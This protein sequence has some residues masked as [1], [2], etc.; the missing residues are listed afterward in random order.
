MVDIDTGVGAKRGAGHAARW[1][2]RQGGPGPG[3]APTLDRVL[4]PTLEPGPDLEP[5]L[6]RL[7][8][9]RPVP[10]DPP[11]LPDLPMLPDLAAA[12]F[13]PSREDINPLA[14]KHVVVVG[15]HYAPE[16]TGVAPYTTAM[17]EHLA[18][19]ARLVTVLTGLPH[20]PTWRVPA[21]YRG[22]GRNP[23]LHTPTLHLVRHTHSVPRRMTPWS[24]LRYQAGF[25]LR[26]SRTQLTEKPDLV[27]AVT[28]SPSSAIAGARLAE[29]YGCPLV[30]VVHDLT[31]S[32]GRLA[33]DLGTGAI[34][35]ARP[36]GTIAKLE[37]AA[38]CR[39]DRVVVRSEAM[40]GA[41]TAC[42]VAENRVDAVPIWPALHPSSLSRND[43][44][45]R[46]GWARD[47]FTVVY[48]GD[49]GPAQGLDTV[50][51]AARELERR[52]VQASFVLAGD[53]ENRRALQQRLEAGAARSAR[54]VDQVGPDDASTILAAAD[55]LVLSETPGVG[56]GWLPGVAP[57][58]LAAGRA[59]VAAVSPLGVVGRE[60]V[61]SGA[62]RLVEPGEPGLLADEIEALNRSREKRVEL[63]AAALA[64]ADT[65]YDR[66]ETMRGLETTV[67]RVLAGV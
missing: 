52:G 34:V 42:G 8:D 66:S 36:S 1:F 27:I 45:K 7:L 10:I 39:A 31:A 65:A 18:T 28:P 37:A 44:R 22:F 20:Y 13:L 16:P 56:V 3:T 55:L 21:A 15:I 33:E 2:P 23:E 19:R 57:S 4:D 6:D 54:V 43:A 60:L 48:C 58:Y 9:R 61:R 29:R 24:V 25:A 47:R 38:L 12:G 40:V 11:P 35:S 62:G 14:D 32:R 17:A 53:G 26:A 46:L 5:M 67:A 41:V 50:V 49:M 51:D 64:Y 30:T 63:A 59:I